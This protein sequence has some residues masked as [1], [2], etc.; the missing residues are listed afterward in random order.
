M[1]FQLKSRWQKRQNDIQPLANEN[2]DAA[3][4]EYAKIEQEFRQDY[5]LI[6]QTATQERTRINELHENNLDSILDIAKKET[7]QKLN[8]AWNENPIKVSREIFLSYIIHY[9]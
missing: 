4:K 1:K 8:T 3:Q 6:K 2:P 9:V 5:D 7:Y